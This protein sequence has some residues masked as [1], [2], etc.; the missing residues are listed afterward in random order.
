MTAAA[1]LLLSGIGSA[2]AEDAS[3]SN[4]EL[5]DQTHVIMHKNPGCACCDKWADHMRSYGFSVTNVEDPQLFAFKKEQKI[6]QPL[7]SCHTAMVG[8][9]FVEGHVP[10]ND[11]LRLL[12]EKPEHV[13]GI[14][15]PAM[16]PRS[17]GMEHSR[18]Q[19][20]KT[21]ALLSDGSAYIFES[22]DAGEDFSKTSSTPVQDPQ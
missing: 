8:G 11:V 2:S 5:P 19:A 4:S 3:N 12:R 6:P 20:F 15:V 1:C 9:Y 17:P 16:P 22:H 18:P 21:V 13:S 10:A 7:M 14:A